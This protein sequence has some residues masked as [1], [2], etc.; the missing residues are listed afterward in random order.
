MRGAW[1]TAL[2]HVRDARVA[3]HLVGLLDWDRSTPVRVAALRQLA[4]IAGHD[5]GADLQRLFLDRLRQDGA[6]EVRT[7][8]AWAL[9]VSGRPDARA[10]IEGALKLERDPTAQAALRDVLDESPPAPDAD[11]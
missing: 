6:V 9:V 8:A 7:A 5:A 3:P 1:T 10:L 11:K 2:E 4:A